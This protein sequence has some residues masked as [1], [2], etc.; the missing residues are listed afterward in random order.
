[1]VGLTKILVKWKRLEN[2]VS[3]TWQTAFAVRHRRRVR[4]L[5]GAVRYRR[6]PH[7]PRL[8]LNAHH[9]LA[10]VRRLMLDAAH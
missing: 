2:V 5:V 7:V 1:V 8:P 6:R 4:Q 3:M 9:R 10:H